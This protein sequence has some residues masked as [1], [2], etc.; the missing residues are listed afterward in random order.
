MLDRSAGRQ[1]R[2]PTSHVLFDRDWPE[3]GSQS[4]WRAVGLAAAPEVGWSSSTFWK[5]RPRRQP[6]APHTTDPR[7]TASRLLHPN[8]GADATDIPGDAG[9]AFRP[10]SPSRRIFCSRVLCFIRSPLFEALFTCASTYCSACS[11]PSRA[12]L[13]AH[14]GGQLASH[15][16]P[17]DV[18]EVRVWQRSQ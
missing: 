17:M 3:R 9:L 11:V 14:L 12:I 6:S 15:D 8:Q 10:R 13:D 4:A 7:R 2:V 1:A 16:H 18:T 5:R